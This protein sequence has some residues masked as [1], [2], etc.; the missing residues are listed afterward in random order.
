MPVLVHTT[1]NLV[2]AGLT[3]AV[4]ISIFMVRLKTLI[5]DTFIIRP[6]R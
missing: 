2:E 1:I 3:Y 5:L 6:P 4:M